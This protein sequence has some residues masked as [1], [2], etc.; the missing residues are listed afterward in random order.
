MLKRFGLVVLVALL[1]QGGWSR[2]RW[3]TLAAFLAP[4]ALVYAPYFAARAWYYGAALPNTFYAKAGG[5]TNWATGVRYVWQFAGRYYLGVGF[6]ILGARAVVGLARGE[7]MSPRSLGLALW[8]VAHVVYVMRIGGDFMEGRFLVPV[9]PAFLLLAE[10]ALR[11]LEL[12]SS[13]RATGFAAVTLA[14]VANLGALPAAQVVAGISDE[15]TRE[16]AFNDW[17]R[18][19]AAFA[20][21][22]PPGTVI[23]T[24]ALGAFGWAA[25]DLVLVDTQGLTDAYVARLPM[26]TRGR[27]GHDRSAPMDYL[28]RRGAALLR[29]GTWLYDLGRRP[30][31]VFAG[32]RY[33]LLRDDPQLRAAFEAVRNEL[34]RP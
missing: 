31:M 28:L 18:E 17:A 34:A 11:S 30:D 27:P 29:D 6:F 22:L 3:S 15:R 4:F 32:N 1:A 12:P 14:S 7:R 19:G 21:H 16:P 24:D 23:A 10:V 2:A 25:K 33:Y 5:G 13:V 26:T 20:R 8:I 9:L